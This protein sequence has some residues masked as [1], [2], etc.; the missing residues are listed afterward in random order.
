MH[1]DFEYKVIFD[2]RMEPLYQKIHLTF[3][4]VLS[5]GNFK[6]IHSFL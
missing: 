6:L 1:S 3:I 2:I 4:L 5:V